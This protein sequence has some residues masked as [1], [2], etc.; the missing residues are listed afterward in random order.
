M[1]RVSVVAGMAMLSMFS[2]IASPATL[3]EVE[4]LVEQRWVGVKSFR[5]DISI[6]M[7][8]PLGAISVPSHAEGTIELIAGEAEGKYRLDITNHLAKSFVLRDGLTQDVLTIFDGEYEYTELTVFGR[9]QVNKRAPVSNDTNRPAGG[10]AVFDRL[11]KQGDVTLAG[12]TTIDGTP[13]WIIDVTAN[14]KPVDVEGPIEPVRIRVFI[15][16]D[17]GLQVRLLMFD[18]KNKE[19]LRM[20]YSNV[21]LNPDLDATRFQYTPPPGVEVKEG[22]PAT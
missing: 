14:G 13:V 3:E 16:K 7:K 18:K 19:L 4:R 9:K 10:R 6:K 20:R 22:T 11:R 1:D 15:A 2:R 21:Q 5:A 12:E 8:V 17:S